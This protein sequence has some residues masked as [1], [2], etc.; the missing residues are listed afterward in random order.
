LYSKHVL[1]KNEVTF[2]KISN[3]DK[4]LFTKLSDYSPLF[5]FYIRKVDKS[6]RK[7]SRGKSGKYTIM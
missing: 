5:S 1:I 3:L 4:M 2:N 6:I 7:H